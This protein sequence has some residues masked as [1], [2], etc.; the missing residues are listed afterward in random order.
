MVIKFREALAPGFPEKQSEKLS[1]ISHNFL[2]E[3][4]KLPNGCRAMFISL[5][6]ENSSK[7]F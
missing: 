3:I 1:Y 5:Q 2:L 4:G 7:T 6:E